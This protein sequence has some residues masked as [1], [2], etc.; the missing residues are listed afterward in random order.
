MAALAI[1]RPILHRPPSRL[2]IGG[3]ALVGAML[4]VALVRR[5][6]SGAPIGG[7]SPW[8]A[9]HLATVIPAL[10]LGAYVMIRR[11]GDRLHRM[12]GRTWAILMIVTAIASFGVQSAGHLS[13]IHILS[14]LVLFS[15]PRGVVMAMR[16]RIDAHRR[17]MTNV[18]IGLIVAGLFVFLPGRLLGGWLFG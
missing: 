9:L 7:V 18:Y 10:P 17:I 4:L 5:L 12:F 2:I 15:V 3:A 14:V 6:N 1:D 11:K 8:L 16:G 13:W